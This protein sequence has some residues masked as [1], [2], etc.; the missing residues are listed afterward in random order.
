MT[1]TVLPDRA[2]IVF[3]IRSLIC[4]VILDWTLYSCAT[5]E[6]LLGLMTVFPA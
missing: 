4:L 1:A 6:M 3:S 5:F 2:V